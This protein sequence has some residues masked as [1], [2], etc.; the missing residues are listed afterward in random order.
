MKA[1]RGKIILS[2][3]LTS[4]ISIALT[5]LVTRYQ[6]L[7]RF[8]LLA[9]DPGAEDFISYVQAYHREHGSLQAAIDIEPFPTFIDRK[10]LAGE[11]GPPIEP[12]ISFRPFE[13]PFSPPAEPNVWTEIQDGQAPRQPPH[14]PPQYLVLDLNGEII[15]SPSAY[16][17]GLIIPAEGLRHATP[18]PVNGQTVAYIYSD[19]IAALTEQQ[20]LYFRA[21]NDSW[22]IALFVVAALAIP[23]GIVLGRRVAGPIDSLDRAMRAMQ[24]GALVQKVRVT[25]KDE[26]GHLSE[27]FNKM[28]KDLSEAYEE[29]EQSR[30][31]MEEL[32][33]QD[34][35][36]LLPN[37]RAFDESASVIIT[38]AYR[39]G[40]ICVLAMIDVDRF[41]EINDTY[42]HAKGDVVLKQLAGVLRSNLREVDILARYGGEEFMVLLPETDLK[43]AN[44]LI[45]RLRIFISEYSWADID[46]ELQITVS[47]GLVEVNVNDMSAEPLEKAI[48][49][50]DKKLYLAKDNGRNRTES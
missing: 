35:L 38:Q 37:R 39:H 49:A 2:L 33:L 17:L 11:L 28:S 9:K 6:I 31:K 10:R 4:F 5:G 46:P 13:R 3:I 16:D 12:S 42:S 14:P 15:L 26:L 20:N 23:V 30:Q 44:D 47:A 1:L 32:S 7:D 48:N 36:T 19:T 29:L 41:K 34:P 8:D 18:I 21:I 40:R 50:A 25:S 22:W 27:S 43:T 24:P 45:E